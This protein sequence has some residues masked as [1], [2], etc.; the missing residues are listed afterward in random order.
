M[1]SLPL[2]TRLRPRTLEEFV[3]QKH[4]VSQNKPLYRAYHSKNLHS[5]ILWGPPGVG[6]TTLAQL[7][8]K[9]VNLPIAF[10]SAVTAGV[11]EI[12]EV[13]SHQTTKPL[14][15]F[16]D[17]IHRFNKAQQD[18]F[19]PLIEQ[20]D[21]ILIGA[22]TENPSFSLNNALL[23]RARVY[24]FKTLEIDEL[25]GLIQWALENEER[26]FGQQTVC[27]PPELRLILAQSSDGD[28]RRLL[29]FLELAVES[30]EE[31][32]GT[33]LIT[34]E[35]ISQLASG[36][37]RRFDK[38]GDVFYQQISAL[39]KSIRGSHPDAALYWLAR[40][41]EAGCDPLYVARRM[42]RVAIEDIGNADP[43]ALQ[44]TLNAFETL[45]RLGSPEGDLSLA[46]A[47]IY[48]A[49]A[50]KSNAVYKAFNEALE[51]AK[52]LGSLE[53][54]PHL[55]N[56]PTRLLKEIGQGK[57]YRYAHDEPHAYAVGVHYFPEKMPNK[58]YYYP[59]ENQGLERQIAEK[60]TQLRGLEKAR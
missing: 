58:R 57:N 20:G 43:R 7:L 41:L 5:M 15:L 60:L 28:A 13:L 19:L 36:G 59:K 54:P 34:E 40:M 25:L 45:E 33:L 12:R 49:C 50:A 56:A 46:Q 39:H 47:V 42:V 38:Q 55:C 10:V 52:N 37:L 3:G 2:A 8:A 31:K 1:K 9:Q 24:L 51:D 14:I 23:S 44:L 30:A 32:N 35:I 26:G 11:K 21:I 4:L 16:I 29:N 17:E 53:V 22:T 18:L 48:L 6:K 27:F